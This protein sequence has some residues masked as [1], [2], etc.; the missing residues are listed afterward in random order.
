MDYSHSKNEIANFQPE[1]D[2]LTK[3][4]IF[5]SQNLDFLKLYSVTLSIPWILTDWWE[6]QWNSS[7]FFRKF[8][9][10][11]LQ[12]NPTR[13]LY[14]FNLNLS[15]NIRLPKDI[16]LELTGFYD[17]KMMMGIWE[18]KPIGSL[19]IGIQKTLKENRGTLRLAMDDLF[20]TNVW[21]MNTLISPEVF[22]HFVGDFHAQS[23]RLTY[24]RSFGN[25][26]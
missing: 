16:K 14:N 22:S 4:Q 17:S 1:I 18:F 2:P 7:G 20:Y 25:K 23:I 3:K 21:N 26:S 10:S 15:N 12:E 8:K 24:N 9:T 5:R 13:D 6:I 19:N 11:H